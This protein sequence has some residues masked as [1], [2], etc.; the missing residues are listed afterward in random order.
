VD[1]G[2]VR[3]NKWGILELRLYPKGVDI[4]FIHRTRGHIKM[5]VCALGSFDYKE[6]LP[7]F[8]ITSLSI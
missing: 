8:S 6:F 1:P 4:V 7:H 2:K 3:F 5:Q